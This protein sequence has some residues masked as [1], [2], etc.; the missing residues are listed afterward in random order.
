MEVMRA[1]QFGSFGGPEVLRV[2]SVPL[3]VPGRGEVLVQVRA[4]TV[5]PPTCSSVRERCVS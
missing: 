5:N 3:P 1:V 2:G 4:S